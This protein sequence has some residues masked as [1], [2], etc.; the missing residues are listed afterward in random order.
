M[1]KF[2]RLRTMERLKTLDEEVR[3]ASRHP[4]DAEAIHDVRVAIRRFVQCLKIFRQF[5]DEQNSRKIRRR[6]KKLM[7]QCAAVRNC[8]IALDLLR[9]AGVD[10]EAVLKAIEGNRTGAE[11]TLI[12]SLKRWRRKS[13]GKTWPGRL[14][15]QARAGFWEIGK[16]PYDAARRMLPRLAQRLFRLGNAAAAPEATRESMHQFRIEAKRFRYTV[17]LF[18]PVYGERL[19]EPLDELKTLQDKLGRLNDCVTTAEMVQ[20]HARAASSVARLAQR[21]ETEF[22]AHWARH[23]DP[24]ARRRWHAWLSGGEAEKPQKK[25]AHADLHPQA[26]RSRVA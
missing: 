21:C 20:E 10:D 23:F 19:E 3:S 9:E 11:N 6:L 25:E 7:D 8:D 15:S 13:I 22:R 4:E 17:E 5:L 14:E 16:P 2:A 24:S 12:H 26:R 1:K 18:K